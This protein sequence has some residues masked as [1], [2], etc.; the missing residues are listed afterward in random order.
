[1]TT[2]VLFNSIKYSVSI[3]KGLNKI[4]SIKEP[5]IDKMLQQIRI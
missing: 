1:M 4:E 2:S 5:Y 3:L